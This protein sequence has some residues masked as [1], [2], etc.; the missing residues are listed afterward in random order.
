[1]LCGLQEKS[2][3]DTAIILKCT[4]GTIA[5]RMNRA[6]SLLAAKLR[7]WGLKTASESIVLRGK[8]ETDDATAIKADGN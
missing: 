4:E 2:Y 8:E 1:M 5:S 3:R 6:K 7:L